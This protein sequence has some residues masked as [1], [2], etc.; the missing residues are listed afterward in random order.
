[1]RRPARLSW[2]EHELLALVGAKFTGRATVIMNQG[3]TV[4][5]RITPHDADPHEVRWRAYHAE[6]RTKTA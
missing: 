6:R 1:M 5:V 3:G 2:L 4:A